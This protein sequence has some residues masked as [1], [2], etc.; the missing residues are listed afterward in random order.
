[1]SHQ[2]SQ[3]SLSIIAYNQMVFCH[4]AQC[5]PYIVRSSL[6]NIISSNQWACQVSTRLY[7]LIRWHSPSISISKPE[8]S[9]L[10]CVNCSF[11][12]SRYSVVT[13]F[14]VKFS[15]YVIFCVIKDNTADRI[16]DKSEGCWFCRLAKP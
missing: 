7:T 11:F 9:A 6:A 1:M 3:K 13:I 15:T 10:L 8:P 2:A 5:C 12:V 4:A 16:H 14:W